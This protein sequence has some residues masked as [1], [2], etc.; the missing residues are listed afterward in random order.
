[1]FQN[2][3][4]FAYTL[5]A[6]RYLLWSPWMVFEH[7]LSLTLCI[8]FVWKLINIGCLRSYLYQPKFVRFGGCWFSAV[9]QLH[10]H[11]V[12][13]HY[14]DLFQKRRSSH[15]PLASFF[16]TKILHSLLHLCDGPKGN[17]AFF[18]AS[19]L[20]WWYLHWSHWSPEFVLDLVASLALHS[21]CGQVCDY[22]LYYIYFSFL[23][24]FHRWIPFWF[25]HT[26]WHSL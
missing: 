25:R 22:D 24:R 16:P 13:S 15:L 21:F 26:T 9:A 11:V 17:F 2:L 6:V 18:Y 10:R 19:L 12:P 3:S 1:M 14:F 7:V 20:V 4:S 5:P 23:R 8:P